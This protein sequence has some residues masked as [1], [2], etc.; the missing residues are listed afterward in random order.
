MTISISIVASAA[1]AG[2]RGLN[3]RHHKQFTVIN[4][5][6]DDATS[7]FTD[8]VDDQDDVIAAA[9]RRSATQVRHGHGPSTG[10]SHRPHTALTDR[11]PRG[12]QLPAVSVDDELHVRRQTLANGR[13]AGDRHYSGGHCTGAVTPGAL[14]ALPNGGPPTMTT[15]VRRRH[16]SDDH[17]ASVV[18]D[19][20][21]EP[22]S[23]IA[24]PERGGT[25]SDSSKADAG[26][27][28]SQVPADRK[29]VSADE[30]RLSGLTTVSLSGSADDSFRR[31]VDVARLPE[32]ARR[33]RLFAKRYRRRLVLQSGVCNVSFANVDRRGARL[34]MDIFTTLLEMKW[35]YSCLLALLI[36]S[37]LQVL[38]KIC[39]RDNTSSV[40]F[41]VFT[42]VVNF[43]NR[44]S[45]E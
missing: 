30:R 39:R 20:L 11:A 1:A 3:R 6:R 26:D 19:L 21:T 14:L 42:P 5:G 15:V 8:D 12:T 37:L 10:A 16:W 34:L 40:N 18:V 4:Y 23:N 7:D 13:R 24:V 17:R 9:R 33:G 35:R 2:E 44:Y 28:E 38:L 36:C 32:V 43:E 45:P 41:L 27:A 22:D 31:T 25:V 29:S